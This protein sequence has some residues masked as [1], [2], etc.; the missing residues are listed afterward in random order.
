MRGVSSR[1][2]NG[3]GSEFL[4]VAVAVFTLIII[5]ACLVAVTWGKS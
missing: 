1:W 3:D 4:A 5:L 2:S